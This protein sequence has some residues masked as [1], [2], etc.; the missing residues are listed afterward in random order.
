VDPL[1]VVDIANPAAIRVLGNLII[2]GYSEYLQPLDATHLIGIGINQS[3]PSWYDRGV[4]IAIFDVADVAAPFEVANLTLGGGGTSTPAFSDQHAVLLDA[5]RGIL[6]LPVNLVTT[7][8]SATG[9]P[10]GWSGTLYFQGA[11]VLNVSVVN[12]ISVR[13][14]VTHLGP[15]TSASTSSYNYA[16]EVRRSITIGDTLYTVSDQLVKANA[17]GDLATISSVQYETASS[18]WSGW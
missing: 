7:N 3:A 14:T 17:L 10:D 2:P 11:F 9:L 18:Y 12:G 13:G 6:V 15:G 1:F 16:R 8:I 5:A 4:R